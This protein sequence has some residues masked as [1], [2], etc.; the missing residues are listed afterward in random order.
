MLNPKEQ[1][2]SALF[3]D[4]LRQSSHILCPMLGYNKEY[5]A[6]NDRICYHFC[7]K[8]AETIEEKDISTLIRDIKKGRYVFPTL[9]F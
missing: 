1:G 7:L 5:L 4:H 8:H 2:I 9:C 6:I 3:I